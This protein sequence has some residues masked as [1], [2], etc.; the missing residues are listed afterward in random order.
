MQPNHARRPLAAVPLTLLVV[1]IACLPGPRAPEVPPSGTLGLKTLLG[2]SEETGPLK[3]VYTSP[4]GTLKG[5]S[6]IT[7]LFNKPMRS[8]EVAAKEAPFPATV[9]PAIAG[10]WQ[11]AGTRAASFIPAREGGGGALRLPKATKFTVTIPKGTK[12]ADGDA[13]AEEH[14]FEFETERP[15]VVSTSPGNRATGLEPGAVFTLYTDQPLDDAEL[16]KHL[17]IKAAGKPV[18]AQVSR[19][20]PKNEKQF[21]VTPSSPLPVDATIELLV[22]A[23]LKGKEGP[24]ASEKG[25]SFF[26]ET[27]GPLV[28]DEVR[29][30]SYRVGAKCDAPDGIRV[31]LSNPVKVKDLK[32]A[33]SVDPPVKLRWPSWMSDDDEYSELDLNGSFLP[34]KSYTVSVK[35]PL[36]DVFGQALSKGAD[37]LVA[38]GDLDPIAR[39]GVTDGV[40][41]G[42]AKREVTV[43]H[44]N[45]SDLDVGLVKLD[46]DAVL[47]IVNDKL[48]FAELVKRPGFTT[49]RLG[50]GR[51]N[52]HERH[53][54]SLDTALGPKGKGPFAI[55]A[56]YTSNGH[57]ETQRRVAQLT[58]L[59]VSAKV[60]AQGSL[61]MVTRLADAAPVSGAEV[62]IRRPGKPAV[63]RTTDAQGFAVFDKDFVPEFADET[64]VIFAKKDG[65]VAFKPVADNVWG[66]AFEPGE[67]GPIGYM[68]DDRG[69][70]RP[71]ETAHLKGI[72]RDPLPTGMKTPS[73]GT[74]IAITVEGPDGDKIAAIPAT[75]TPFGTFTADIKIPI[76]GRLGT[77]WVRAMRGGEEIAQETLE[78]AE[79]RPTEFKVA[80]ESDKSSY[81][82]GDAAK[83]LGRGDYLY[84]APMNGARAELSVSRGFAYFSP[85]DSA[86]FV[87]SDQDYQSDLPYSS[88]RK[89]ELTSSDVSLDASGT[90][91][92]S[93]KLD[94]PGMIGPER[95]R[96]VLDVTDVS[97]QQVSS[98][99]TAIVH[100]AEHYVGVGLDRT[101][102]EAKTKL[103]PTFIAVK[104]GGDRVAGAPLK[105]G[106]IK[107]TWA[108]AKQGS[109]GGSA[110]TLSSAVDTVVSSCALTSAKS[111]VSCDLTPPD[112]GRYIVRVTSEDG[113]KNPVAAS[114]DVYVTGESS[115]ALSAFAEGDEPTI[116]LVTDR[117]TYKVGDK[118]KILVKS[119]WKSAEALL[120]VERA[121][122]FEHRRVQLTGAAPSV[123]VTITEDMRPN[124]FVSVLVHKGRTKKAPASDKPDVGAPDYLHGQTNL[125]VDPASKRLK[126][127]VRPA[128]SDL[129]PGEEAEIALKVS[130]VKGAGVKTELTVY[131]ADE[132]V[133]SL[134]DY[135]LPNPLDTFAAARPLRVATLESRDKLATLFDP[136]SGLGLDKGLAGGGGD[137]APG[138]GVRGDFRASAYYNAAV[139]TNDAGEATVKFKLPDGLTTYRVMAVAASETDRFGAGESRVTT[140]RVLMARP[141]L[142]R[143][144][145]AG[146]TFEASVIVSSKASTT[147]EV[148]VVAK[149]QGVVAR[150]DTKKRVTVDAGKS[151]EVRFTADAPKIGSAVIQFEVASGAERDAVRVERKVQM[152][153]SFE[154]V[155]LYGNTET[156]AAERLGDLSEIRDDVGELVM[157]TSS[158]A[159]VG[160]DAGSSQLLEYPYGCTEQ[161]TSKLVPLVA[162]KDLAKDFGLALPANT[163]DVV[164]KTIAKILTHQRYDGSFGFW[165]DSPQPSP[166]ATTYALWGLSEA[167]KRGH[168]VPAAALDRATQYLFKSLDSGDPLFSAN[169]GPFVLY[170]LAELGK[171]DPG[172]AATLF[173]DRAKLPLYSKAL[174]TSAMALGK[175]DEASVADLVKDLEASIRLDGNLARTA[176]NLGDDYAVYLDSDARTSALVLRALLHAKPSHPLAPNLAM[177]LLAGRD[178]GQ[179]RSTQEGAWALLALG[180][181]RKA[182]EAAEPNFS[183]QVF[184]GDAL[185]SE[186]EFRGRSV[187]PQIKS[188]ATKDLASQKGSILSMR[189]DGQGKLFYEARLKYARKTLPTDVIDRGF[190]VEH[191]LRKVTPDTLDEVLA[192]VPD[193]TLETFQGGDLILA[194][195]LVVTPKPRRYVAIDAPLP[196]GFE[197][198]DTRLATTSDR[199]RGVDHVAPS[200]D[201]GD[202]AMEDAE[203]SSYY[204]REVRDDR[205]L[206]FVDSMAAGVYRYRYLARATAMG[207]FITPPTKVEEMYAP[208]I[209]GRTGAATIRVEPK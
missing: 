96:C 11:W 136:L 59:A 151:V 107:R 146:D 122:V 139:V 28:V 36:T 34:G 142:P 184:F 98:T 128:R 177:G 204:T 119:P 29:C 2:S 44:I 46:E 208:E 9:E 203:W 103:S 194:D 127:E 64:A 114:V 15:R 57:P 45:T 88:L 22:G 13:L 179:F 175:A 191:R 118:A 152:P 81:V 205:V 6:E 55:T 125:L 197:A 154:S 117:E 42:T 105:V 100:P 115:G 27:Y 90:A 192:T 113:R 50:A 166:W 58:D 82:R 141:A 31:R 24:L 74:P 133:L 4:K 77:Y 169:V 124:A 109:G 86:G 66:D 106:L 129:R 63:V 174:L 110:T 167:K 186:Q 102:V 65:D 196:A 1:A 193:A 163:D 97:R 21:R 158:T 62:R 60:S 153:L 126:V 149:L 195:V 99:T 190:Y 104:P 3:V 69:I 49:T 52:V 150:G 172:R 18:A 25:Q 26:F 43:A 140:S 200:Y 94:L 178:G 14:R 121:G 73:V 187:V 51:K 135:T 40:L 173:A 170:V 198:V 180:D 144:L 91:S 159:L 137:D 160:L 161:L 71:G 134:V 120:T 75:T 206:F 183:A 7:V 76:S 48:S 32:K 168:A 35:S 84:G 164:E 188:F 12:S 143:F 30:A 93:A 92:T 131:A 68:F 108:V 156:A 78:V 101:F 207:A 185:V 209:F 85:P 176:E 132:G 47:A 53:K 123:E 39:I 199:L 8:L 20:D 130:D 37:A 155:A 70:Y 61:V 165:P 23:G 111:P 83:W 138:S 10:T 112:A 56:S 201:E 95:V 87:V 145:R 33:L 162:M 89:Y 19:Q 171:P 41:E 202:V 181:Y 54:V 116:E 16:A 17:T 5:P 80:V 147:Q 67:D 79:F 72:L 189:V 38:F 182:Q 157:T 148:D